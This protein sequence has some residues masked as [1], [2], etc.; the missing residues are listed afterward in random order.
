MR[1]NIPS[2]DT[3]TP[4]KELNLQDVPIP[5]RNPAGAPA[6]PTKVVTVVSVIGIFFEE[7][8]FQ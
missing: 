3:L 8:G 1:A 6:A 4:V 7:D 2:L 5:S